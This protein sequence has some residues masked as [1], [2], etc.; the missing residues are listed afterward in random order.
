M[1]SDLLKCNIER[2]I[3]KE[4]SDEDLQ[5]FKNHMFS[6]SFDKKTFLAE[7]DKECKYVYFILKGACVSYYVSDKGDK[8]VIQFAIEGNWI[9]DLYSFFSGQPGVYTIETIEPVE[10]LM[11]NRESFEKAC[12]RQIIDRFFRKLI[13]NAYVDL[14][15]RFVKSQSEEAA[16]CYEDFS[17]N[18]PE[19]VQRIPQ[20]L[21]ASYLGIKP[22]SLSR[23]RKETFKKP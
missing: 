15:Y 12:D 11:L 9:S 1:K 17:K 20:Y 7:T 4:I 8:I 3:G 21:I 6:R 14:K 10:V 22:Q 19:L 23:I 2:F 16:V 5:E 13:Q 18:N